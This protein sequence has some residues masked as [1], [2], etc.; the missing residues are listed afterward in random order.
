MA[1]HRGVV[2]KTEGDLVAMRKAGRVN[3][4]ALAAAVSAVRTG[5]TTAEVNA[6]AEDVLRKNGAGMAFLGYPGPY[7]Y[8]AATYASR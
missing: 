7:P 2:I 1:W 8:P 5:V 4:L 6:A 3:A